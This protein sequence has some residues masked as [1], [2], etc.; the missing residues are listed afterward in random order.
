MQNCEEYIIG[1]LG[2]GADTGKQAD[3]VRYLCTAIEDFGSTFRS[4]ECRK[5]GSGPDGF[6]FLKR[7]FLQGAAE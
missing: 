5:N 7:E 6:A 1:P 2:H 4:S 3:G